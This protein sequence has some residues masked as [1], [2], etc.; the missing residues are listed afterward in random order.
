MDRVINRDCI[1]YEG[2]RDMGATIDTCNK[3]HE[4]GYCPCENCDMYI[5]IDEVFD[6]LRSKIND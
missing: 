2:V 3:Y 6:I 4:L 5:T 1:F